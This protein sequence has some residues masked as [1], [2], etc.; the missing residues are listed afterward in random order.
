[1]DFQEALSG[2]GPHGYWRASGDRMGASARQRHVTEAHVAYLA[3][4][5]R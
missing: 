4:I 5:A 2:R 3:D 1:M